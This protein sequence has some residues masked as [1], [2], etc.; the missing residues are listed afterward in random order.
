MGVAQPSFP[1]WD[2][3]LGHTQTP[4]HTHIHAHIKLFFRN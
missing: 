3:L 1:I 4:Q 2:S